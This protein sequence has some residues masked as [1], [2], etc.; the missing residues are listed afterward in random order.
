MQTLYRDGTDWDPCVYFSTILRVNH[1]YILHHISIGQY[2]NDLVDN[3]FMIYRDTYESLKPLLLAQEERIEDFYI[4][5]EELEA[6][7]K[8][9]NDEMGW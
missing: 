7:M 9:V 4:S 8:R 1:Y 6:E 2:G 5:P 3:A